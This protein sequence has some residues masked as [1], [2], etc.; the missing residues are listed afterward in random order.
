M[1]C[2][3][4]FFMSGHTQFENLGDLVINREVLSRLRAR[5]RVRVAVA[6]VPEEFRCGLCLSGDEAVSSWPSFLAELLRAGA[7]SL[8]DPTAPHAFL[9]LKPGGL[10]GEASVA[11]AG[12]EI[13][14]L[15]L[16]WLLRLVGVRIIRLGVSIGPYGPRRLAIEQRKHRFIQFCGVRDTLSEAYCRDHDLRAVER[17]PDLAFTLPAPVPINSP[18]EQRYIVISFRDDRGGLRLA[19]ERDL[20]AVLDAFDPTRSIAVQPVVQVAFDI[21]YAQSLISAIGESGR[22]IMPLVRASSTL[23]AFSLYGSAEAIFTNRLHVLLLALRAG[24]PAHALVDAEKN[25]KIVGLLSDEGL[26][27]L[28]VN[29]KA[30]EFVHKSTEAS[31]RFAR[32]FSSR[33]AEVEVILDRVVGPVTGARRASGGKVP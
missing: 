4:L 29:P 27:D 7:R 11:Q 12:K 2:S 15:L 17:F 23:A 3:N 8:R 25:R 19:F 21:P 20:L 32:C 1:T 31:E 26:A 33:R 6:G 16:F 22:P 18:L 28:I 13:V 30:P 14:G 24:T 10:G 9:V 5:G